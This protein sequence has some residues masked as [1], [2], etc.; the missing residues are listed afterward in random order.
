[1]PTVLHIAAIKNIIS[2]EG[3]IPEMEII[4]LTL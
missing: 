4:H 2:F 3:K 1:M